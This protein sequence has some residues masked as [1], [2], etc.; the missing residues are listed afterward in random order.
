M[1]RIHLYEY[2]RRNRERIVDAAD[3]DGGLVYSWSNF[4]E[5]GGHLMVRPGTPYILVDVSSLF[6]NEDRLLNTLPYL[7]K[8]ISYIIGLEKYEARLI[9]ERRFSSSAKDL[10]YFKIDEVVSLE[11]ALKLDDSRITDIVDI[12]EEEFASLCNSID[13]NLFGNNE[14]KAIFF[15]QLSRFRIFNRLGT[16]HIFS[17]FLYGNSGIGKTELGRLLTRYLAPGESIIKINFGNY[18]GSNALNS[19]I[20][21]PRG[22]VGSSKG[23]LSEKLLNSRSTVIVIDEFEKAAHEVHNFFLQLLEDGSFT[24]SL[25]RDYDLDKY[26]VLF[27]SN[28]KESEIETTLKPEFRSRL[29]MLSHVDD[30]TRAEKKSYVAFR[31]RELLSKA[32]NLP[33]GTDIDAVTAKIVKNVDVNATNDLR[34]INREIMKNL[35]SVLHF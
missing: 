33:E 10:L 30:I 35:G 24:D 17:A 27:T 7:D 21:S 22:Y 11:E 13:A 34:V 15:D 31:T 6:V 23:E 4:S 8:I 9:V 1:K 14:L 26:I 28:L 3:K 12:E 32:K 5:T 16:Q 29:S 2:D 18:S 20:G 19:L 25:G